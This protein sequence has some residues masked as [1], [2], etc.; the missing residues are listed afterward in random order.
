[1]N[2]TTA[3]TEIPEGK[4][5]WSLK[6]LPAIFW[7]CLVLHPPALQEKTE[8]HL[9]AYDRNFQRTR[10]WIPIEW[11]LLNAFCISEL[12]FSCLK[13]FIKQWLQ[14]SAWQAVVKA[15]GHGETSG[16][17]TVYIAPNW[18]CP[19]REDGLQGSVKGPSWEKMTEWKMSQNREKL[20]LQRSLS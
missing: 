8:I 15:E 17:I 6:T 20:Y 14:C 3:T 11:K 2:P 9:G 10:S 5:M 13:H 1:M 4:L 16:W 18:W 12:I 7:H 19:V